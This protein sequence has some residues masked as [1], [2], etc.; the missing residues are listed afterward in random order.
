MRYASVMSEAI[1]ATR[2]SFQVGHDVEFQISCS[3]PAL[4]NISIGYGSPDPAGD[5]R[6]GL[7]Q[8]SPTRAC[9]SFKMPLSH[10]EFKFGTRN[11]TLYVHVFNLS[12]PAILQVAFSQHRA[13]DL[14]QFFITFSR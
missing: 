9:G 6:A 8:V 1:K 7:V 11:A 2:C 3:T 4:V 10:E 5:P 12:T 14:L 13:L